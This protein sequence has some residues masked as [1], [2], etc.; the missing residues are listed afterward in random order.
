M[1]A[2]VVGCTKSSGD[3]KKKTTDKNKA[4]GT[5]PTSAIHSMDDAA[6]CRAWIGTMQRC[7]PQLIAAIAKAMNSPSADAAKLFDGLDAKK[8]CASPPKKSRMR[9]KYACH[10]KTQCAQFSACY[11]T[12]HKAHRASKVLEAKKYLKDI[13]KGAKAYFQEPEKKNNKAAV[14]SGI[15]QLPTQFP[16]PSTDASI[17]ADEIE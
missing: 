12:A 2:A 9:S 16:V 15:T 14:P 8:L 17:S 13:Y 10:A 1:V 11:V 5:A 6:A 3:D 4:I 7:K